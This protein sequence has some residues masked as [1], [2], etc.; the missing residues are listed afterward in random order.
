MTT[1]A[2][3]A[4]YDRGFPV[5]KP[6]DFNR[7]CVVME[8]MDSFPLAS[9]ASV[10]DPGQVCQM[11]WPLTVPALALFATISYYRWC[12]TPGFAAL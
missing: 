1:P 8:L 11:M 5:P 9:V 4:L 2:Q 10:D 12:L 7:H 3:K 6:V